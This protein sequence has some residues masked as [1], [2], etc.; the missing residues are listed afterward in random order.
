MSQVNTSTLVPLPANGA[1][2]SGRQSANIEF[3]W[4]IVT[5]LSDQ[6]GLL[7]ISEMGDGS[8]A[9]EVVVSLPVAAGVPLFQSRMLRQ[10]YFAITFT[11]GAIA[12]A[13][14]SLTWSTSPVSADPQPARLLWLILKELRA[15]SLL[16]Q[17]LKEP[18]ATQ[19]NLPFGTDPQ[20]TA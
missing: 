6:A 16:L 15:Q 5:L 11:N 2:S 8:A 9:P 12:E 18:S 10:Q 14:L 4:V 13:S 7:T 19:V 20:L 1:Y 17:S 3:P